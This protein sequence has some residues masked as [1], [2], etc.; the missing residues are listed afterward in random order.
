MLAHILRAIVMLQI[1]IGRG[2]G[3]S[4][5][6]SGTDRLVPE[7]VPGQWAVA[8]SNADGSS[9]RACH[10]SSTHPPGLSHDPDVVFFGLSS[11]SEKPR[12]LSNSCDRQSVTVGAFSIPE[13]PWHRD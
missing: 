1:G 5:V 13:T 2:G 10:G 3:A 12:R 11:G 7:A 4:S 6:R 8:A 9:I